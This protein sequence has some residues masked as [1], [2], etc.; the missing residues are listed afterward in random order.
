MITQEA[1]V[2]LNLEGA[3]L[4][5]LQVT[6]GLTGSEACAL[7]QEILQYGQRPVVRLAGVPVRLA[8]AA[9]GFVLPPNATM[10]QSDVRDGDS[11]ELSG[12]MWVDGKHGQGAAQFRA[13]QAKAGAGA[14]PAAAVAAA[15]AATA[16]QR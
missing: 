8:V 7:V 3:H 15:S 2:H 12:Y 13:A 9:T 10:A 1:Y 16:A 5:D 6:A 4:C 14:S 11:L